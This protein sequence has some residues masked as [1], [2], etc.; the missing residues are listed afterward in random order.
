M[1]RE[2]INLISDEIMSLVLSHE[3]DEA[4]SACIIVTVSGALAYKVDKKDFLRLISD[5]YD[6]ILI[7]KMKQ[8]E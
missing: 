1:N 4:L 6:D 2:K 5:V 8:N 3:P 7:E